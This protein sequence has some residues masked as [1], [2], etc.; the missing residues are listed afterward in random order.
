MKKFAII[1]IIIMIVL[2]VYECSDLVN[3][4]SANDELIALT[5][6]KIENSRKLLKKYDFNLN[7][8][9][10]AEEAANFTFDFPS[11]KQTIMDQRFKSFVED[12]LIITEGMWVVYPN[13]EG[14]FYANYWKKQKKGQ[15]VGDWSEWI[16]SKA[17]SFSGNSTEIEDK[18]DELCVRYVFDGSKDIYSNKEIKLFEFNNGFVKGHYAK[19][20]NLQNRSY[21]YVY[22]DG[23]PKNIIR[24]SRSKA[25]DVSAIDDKKVQEFYEAII[26]QIISTIRIAN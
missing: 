16:K 9:V 21:I 4:S 2:V 6:V 22:D 1:F 7:K 5:E 20:E 8:N 19:S 12:D 10:R 17:D 3:D 13:I 25:E 11:N 15:K 26:M 18:V 23:E 14:K 24:I